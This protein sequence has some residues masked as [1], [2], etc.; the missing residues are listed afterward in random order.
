MGTNILAL[1]L[2]AV[3]GALIGYERLKSGHVEAGRRTMALV[4]FGACL[5]TIIP[6]IA[7]IPSDVW[8][9]PAAVIQGI[10]F[11][12]AGVLMKEG[13]SVKGLTTSAAIWVSAAIGICYGCGAYAYGA[14]ATAGVFIILITNKINLPPAK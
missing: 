2:S 7:K 10:G 1:F 13:S 11:L 12:C 9:M 14:L 5:F 8:R 4:C 6:T 3:S